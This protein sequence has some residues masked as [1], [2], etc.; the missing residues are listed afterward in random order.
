M[1]RKITIS[2]ERYYKAMIKVIN[3]FLN[4]TEYEIELISNMFVY[5]IKTLD[6]N[7]RSILRKALGTSEQ[8]FN[9]YVKRL[10]D[11]KI[12]I[13]SKSGLGLNPTIEDAIKDEQVTIK[14]DV[15]QDVP[16]N[17]QV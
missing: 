17:D 6:K 15:L 12:L 10:K 5:N 4:L 13:D 8:S 7:S 14:F 2:K 1:E 16:T 9:N 3:C 11:K